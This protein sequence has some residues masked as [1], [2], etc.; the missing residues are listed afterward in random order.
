MVRR[1]CEDLTGGDGDVRDAGA[2]DDGE[3][4]T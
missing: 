4:T 3:M 1:G 2:A